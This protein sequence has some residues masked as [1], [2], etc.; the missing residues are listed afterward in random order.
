MYTQLLLFI[1]ESPVAILVTTVTDRL[2]NHSLELAETVITTTMTYHP[3]TEI[4]LNVST[5]PFKIK[6]VEQASQ[7][8]Q[9]WGF[10]CFHNKSEA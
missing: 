1:G 7:K 3:I 10:L 4:R 8:F 5:I 6:I 9:L 2:S